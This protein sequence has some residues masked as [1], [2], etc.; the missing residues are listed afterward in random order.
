M[1]RRELIKS[2]AVSPFFSG[3]IPE[4][5]LEESKTVLR[6]SWEPRFDRGKLQ[7]LIDGD[8]VY[9]KDIEDYSEWLERSRSLSDQASINI[10]EFIN[11]DLYKTS[12]I[13]GKWWAL[14]FTSTSGHIVDLYNTE[15]SEDVLTGAIFEPHSKEEIAK[16]EEENVSSLVSSV[17]QNLYVLTGNNGLVRSV[18]FDN[19]SEVRIAVIND[20]K[21]NE[22]KVNRDQWQEFAEANIQESGLFLPNFEGFRLLRFYLYE[23][24]NINF[25]FKS[26]DHIIDIYDNTG[27]E[28]FEYSWFA[29]VREIDSDDGIGIKK[30]DFDQLVQAIRE[31]I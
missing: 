19:G 8:E 2:L 23:D 29:R 14:G 1:R 16:I 21:S 5:S 30:N 9:R 6:T 31:A 18:N 4:P 12:V 10:P 20:G 11:F 22:T 28:G 26:D 25:A 7:K 3:F 24:N 17:R 13:D 15:Y 27:R